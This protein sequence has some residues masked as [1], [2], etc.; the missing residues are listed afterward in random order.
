LNQPCSLK[1][2]AVVESGM[3]FIT[4]SPTNFSKDPVINLEF[5]LFITE[6]EKML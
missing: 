5:K 6:V 2:A 4:Q 3:S 1:K